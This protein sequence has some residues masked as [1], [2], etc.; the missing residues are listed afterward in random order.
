MWLKLWLCRNQERHGRWYVCTTCQGLRCSLS[1]VAQSRLSTDAMHIYNAPLWRWSCLMPCAFVKDERNNT[2]LSLGT[3]FS[4]TPAKW[5]L[6]ELPFTSHEWACDAWA[7]TPD[8]LFPH[9]TAPRYS[10]VIRISLRKRVLPWDFLTWSG[11]KRLSFR[12]WS[13]KSISTEL[14]AT[15]HSGL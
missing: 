4:P 10:P 15:M 3:G 5:L 14:P 11:G 2:P 1:A 6:M 7:T 13:P 8:F 9:H 12:F